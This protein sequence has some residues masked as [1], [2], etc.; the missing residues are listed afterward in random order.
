MIYYKKRFNE[1]KNKEAYKDLILTTFFIT[2]LFLFIFMGLNYTTATN[3]AVIIFLQLLFSF[4]YFNLIGKEHIPFIHIVGA[5]MMGAGAIV[6]LFPDDFSFNKGDV[7]ILIAAMIAP[8]ANF[9]QKRARRYVSVEVILLFRYLLSL[10][11]LLALAYIIEPIPSMENIIETS[12]YLI[13]TGILIFGI[14]KI[15]WIE[16]VFLTSITKASAMAAFVPPLTIF[17]AYLILDEIPTLIQLIAIAPIVF[18]GYLI[19][20]AR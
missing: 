20:R 15:F 2:L 7:L 17:F 11:F 4:L 19:T 6:I 1:F 8:I 3:M 14:S 18:G 13:L 12:P 9:Y 16:G 5:L 10:P